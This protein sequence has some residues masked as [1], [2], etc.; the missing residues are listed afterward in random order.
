MGYR[1]S[2]LDLLW[3]SPVEGTVR[4]VR[5]KKSLGRTVKYGA[6][7]CYVWELSKVSDVRIFQF[8]SYC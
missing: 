3:H 5:N 4:L 6:P 8:M 7:H 1:R 2:I